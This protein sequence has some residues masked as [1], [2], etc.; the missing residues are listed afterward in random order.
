MVLQIDGGPCGGGSGGRAI[1]VAVAHNRTRAKKEFDIA[2][3]Y[4]RRPACLSI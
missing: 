1:A 3:S 2:I 4:G